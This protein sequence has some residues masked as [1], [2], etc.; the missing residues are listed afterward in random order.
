[1]EEEQ[2]R[3]EEERENELSKETCKKARAA[4]KEEE[5]SEQ[6]EINYCRESHGK[7]KKEYLNAETVEEKKIR[8]RCFLL[9]INFIIP[10]RQHRFTDILYPIHRFIE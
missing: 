8:L 2:K 9:G 10:A 4:E 1:M 3:K 5:E 7:E 6:G